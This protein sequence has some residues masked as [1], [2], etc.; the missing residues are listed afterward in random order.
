MSRCP[1]CHRAAVREGNKLWPFC[2][3]RCSLADLGRW[4]A[5]EYRVAGEPAGIAAPVDE[6]D[7]AKR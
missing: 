2:C 3:E 4:L 5:E 1:T 7:A 6:D